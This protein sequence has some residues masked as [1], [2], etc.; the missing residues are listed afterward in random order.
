GSNNGKQ[1]G[2]KEN[3]KRR[4]TFRRILQTSSRQPNG[5][6][7]PVSYAGIN[8]YYEEHHHHHHNSTRPMSMIN[9][10]PFGNLER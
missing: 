6:S 4:T 9:V 2:S 10:V 1:D 3:N 8:Q 5:T 7:R